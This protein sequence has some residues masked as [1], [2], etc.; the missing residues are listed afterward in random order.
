MTGNDFLNG[1]HSRSSSSFGK[2]CPAGHVN[3]K[4][5]PGVHKNMAASVLPDRVTVTCHSRI[6]VL[7]FFEDTE[8]T[9]FQHGAACADKL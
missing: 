3:T 9:A 5:G 7:Q 4:E 1:D 6:Y 2:I 8:D